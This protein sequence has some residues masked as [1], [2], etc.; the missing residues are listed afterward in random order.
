MDV[1][2]YEW[3]TARRNDG[4]SIKMVAVGGVLDLCLWEVH[5]HLHVESGYTTKTKVVF[6]QSVLVL[7]IDSFGGKQM[8]VDFSSLID[9][10]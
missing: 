10:S 5:L 6:H 1:M 2:V 9:F 4:R 7:Y 8:N 3:V